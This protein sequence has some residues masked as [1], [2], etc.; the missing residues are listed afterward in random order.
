MHVQHVH[1]LLR[2]KTT[3]TNNKCMSKKER[4]E[5]LLHILVLPFFH[6]R[7]VSLV[8]HRHPQSRIQAS[9]HSPS[10]VPH[11]FSLS[12][13]S[14]PLSIGQNLGQK[15][16]SEEGVSLFSL[17]KTSN[18]NSS[19]ISISF[20][21]CLVRDKKS[22]GRERTQQRVWFNSFTAVHEQTCRFLN[23]YWFQRSCSIF[24]S[25]FH[26]NVFFKSFLRCMKNRVIIA[27]ILVSS[28]CGLLFPGVCDSL[29]AFVFN[30]FLSF[31]SKFFSFCKLQMGLSSCRCFGF[32]TQA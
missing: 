23:A 32:L 10:S 31:R 14:N 30:L 20:C 17:T 1:H 5:L 21:D 15:M 22:T 7:Q 13:A 16:W 29:L 6:L 25:A 3:R 8:F 18:Q 2:K 4:L 19:E 24:F 9:S 11:L 27:V 12:R 28:P 26:F